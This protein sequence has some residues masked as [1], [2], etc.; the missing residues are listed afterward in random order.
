MIKHTQ[1]IRRQFAGELFER[2][3]IFG[4]WRLKG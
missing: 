2:L 3:T 1:A 4:G